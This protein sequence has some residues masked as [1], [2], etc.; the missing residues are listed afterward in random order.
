MY[1]GQCKFD[2]EVR[3]PKRLSKAYLPSQISIITPGF[4]AVRDFAYFAVQTV[5]VEA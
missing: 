5:P 3:I 4:G 1:L 2:L